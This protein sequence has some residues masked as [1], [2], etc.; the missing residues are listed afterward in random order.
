MTFKTPYILI[1]AAV[2]AGTFDTTAATAT[3]QSEAAGDSVANP[4]VG[5]LRDVEVVGVKQLPN[6]Q[7]EPATRLDAEA[8]KALGI[9][10]IR[11]I[12]DVAPN[13]LSRLTGHE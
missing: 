6:S 10:A 11:G 2:M 5:Y 12:S 4:V 1:G 8:V 3:V 9:T 7:I 13:F